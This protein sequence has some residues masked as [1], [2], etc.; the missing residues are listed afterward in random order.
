MYIVAEMHCFVLWGGCF[1]TKLTV[2]IMKKKRVKNYQS[3]A[4]L[5]LN[6]GS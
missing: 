2:I 6:T 4:V 1:W 5:R 3:A